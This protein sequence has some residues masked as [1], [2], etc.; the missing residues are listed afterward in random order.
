MF[1]SVGDVAAFLAGVFG[2]Q[3]LAPNWVA[4]SGKPTR[5]SSEGVGC[6]TTAIESTAATSAIGPRGCGTKSP[7][8][9]D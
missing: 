9:V 8:D 6:L 7:G 3:L 4:E 1:V 5:G 2:G